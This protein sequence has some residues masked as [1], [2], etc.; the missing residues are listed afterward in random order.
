MPAGH[1]WQGLPCTHHL[2][3]NLRVTTVKGS[4]QVSAGSVC[5]AH[6]EGVVSHACV[7][8]SSL[9]LAG[10]DSPAP[11]AVPTRLCAEASLPVHLCLLHRT[12]CPGPG[13][14]E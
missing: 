14:T 13:G 2:P 4:G 3:L 5:R 11:T 12:V 10:E 8:P 6:T 9:L 1:P 7:R